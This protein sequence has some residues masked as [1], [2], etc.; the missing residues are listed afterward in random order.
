MDRQREPVSFDG[1]GL[2]VTEEFDDLSEAE[3]SAVRLYRQPATRRTDG[4]GP[5]ATG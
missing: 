1:P 5:E 3:Q 2:G 4:H